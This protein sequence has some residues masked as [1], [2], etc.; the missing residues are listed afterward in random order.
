[1][2]GDDGGGIHVFE[3]RAAVLVDSARDELEALGLRDGF[4]A[5]VGLE[6]ADDDIDAFVL[7]LL[8]L[9]QHLI[10]LADARRV[11]EK[12]FEF[13][14]FLICARRGPS[15]CVPSCRLPL[16]RL[17]ARVGKYAH[18]HAFGLFDQSIHGILRPEFPRLCWV[19]P[20]KI[21]VTRCSRAKR[22]ISVTGSLAL[23]STHVDFGAQ[24]AGVVE[25][26]FEGFFGFPREVVLFDVEGQ[27]LPVKAL[28]GAG[29]AF[30]HGV[31]AAARGDADQDALLGAP[32][33]HD[34]VGVHVVLQLLLDHLG[35]KQ[36]SQ[37]AKL[38]ELL[39]G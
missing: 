2:A 21:W 33:L 9:R 3:L 26:L 34:A 22:M 1:M 8:G 17:Q 35:G 7:Q 36:Q 29:A 23:L 39:P 6:V 24:L 14:A 32:A 19:W 10:G 20:M 28:R 38:G 11:A 13:A 18:V 5:A 16:C 37:F 31:G 30:E 15:A 4:G 27:Q 12:D 25:I